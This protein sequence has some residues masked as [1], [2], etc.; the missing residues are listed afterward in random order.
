MKAHVL[1]I[2]AES[3]MSWELELMAV[4]AY[5]G[6]KNHLFGQRNL[7]LQ[8]GVTVGV[9]LRLV[10]M[11]GWTGLSGKVPRFFSEKIV[12]ILKWHLIVTRK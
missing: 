4:H 8:I 6:S 2:D 11:D 7:S 10:L 3:D 9:I 1:L 5:T 12:K